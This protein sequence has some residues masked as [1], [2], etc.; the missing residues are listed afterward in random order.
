MQF[1]KRWGLYLLIILFVISIYTDL[2]TGS[3]PK[4][5]DVLPPDSVATKLPEKPGVIRV[6]AKSGDT[7]LSIVEKWNKSSQTMDVAN[8]IS[9]FEKLNP[10]A[11]PHRL[12]PDVFYYFP[13]Y[14]NVP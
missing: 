1:I 3:V 4:K 6:K 2:T 9:D 10:E 12:E 11:D 5:I 14:N 13:I 7:V 8:I